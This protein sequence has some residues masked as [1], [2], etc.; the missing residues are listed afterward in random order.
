MAKKKTSDAKTIAVAFG[1]VNVG[2]Q[3]ARLALHIDR[4]RLS[5]AEADR[6]CGK[7]LIGSITASAG[8][9]NPEQDAI[10]G[11]DAETTLEGSFDVKSFG[12][13]PKSITTGLSFSIAS[14]D[15]PKL[16]S[17]AKRAGTVQIDD[18]TDIPEGEAGEE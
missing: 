11:M 1:N 8:N 15:L 12:F 16:C 17:F 2:D 6:L 14:I 7:R 4:K 18:V 9:D 10:P 5:L 3:I 13:G